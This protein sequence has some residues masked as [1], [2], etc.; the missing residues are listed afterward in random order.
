MNYLSLWQFIFWDV[1]IEGFYE[2]V[3][4]DPDAYL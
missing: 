2:Q 3:R 4:G 1:E